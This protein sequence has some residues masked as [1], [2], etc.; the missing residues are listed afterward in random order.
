MYISIMFFV[1]V[2]SRLELQCVC[3]WVCVCVEDVVDH[4]G[5]P[6]QCCV[7]DDFLLYQVPSSLL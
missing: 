5:T 6:Q 3:L 2:I 7:D 1:S 4:L